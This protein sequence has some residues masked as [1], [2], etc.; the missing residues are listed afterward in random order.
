M[1]K[2]FVGFVLLLMIFLGACSSTGGSTSG[3]GG[4]GGGGGTA[5]GDEEDKTG[6]GL[7]ISFDV[8]EKWLGVRELN[9]E[10]RL[11][12]TG[13][14]DIELDSSNFELRTVQRDF[15]NNDIFE[16]ESMNDFYNTIFKDGSLVL[17]QNQYMNYF[18]QLFIHEGFF[19]NPN[20][21]EFQ[22]VISAQYDYRTEFDNNLEIMPGE[23]IL[24]HDTISQAAPIQV[25]DI[26]L[27]VTR[28]S[29]VIEYTIQDVGPGYFGDEKTIFIE[30]IDLYFAESPLSNCRAYAKKGDD[31]FPMDMGDVFL[32]DE[33][34]RVVI[35]CRINL[36]SYP[37][38]SYTNVKTEGSFEYSYQVQETR[39]VRLPDE[40]YNQ[41]WD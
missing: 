19:D 41:V 7:E 15:N 22:Y 35:S 27:G 1:N 33:Q 29:F 26:E 34:N 13:K 14:F 28:D 6:K 4:K 37:E 12:N 18:G 40:R 2:L 21:E 36:D 3:V 38:F 16:L 23:K 20:N 31:V 25:T 9:Y 39:S 32:S 24:K 30:N 8:D 10:L 11:K 17:R 5:Q